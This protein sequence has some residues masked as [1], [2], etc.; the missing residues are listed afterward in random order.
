MVSVRVSTQLAAGYAAVIVAVAAV[1]VASHLYV[2]AV[3]GDA[4]EIAA[5]WDEADA[6]ASALATLREGCRTPEARRAIEEQARRI[7]SLVTGRP[8]DPLPVH[9][10]REAKIF[11]ATIAHCPAPMQRSS[12]T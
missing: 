8:G 3:E 4:G 5:E 1:A 11:G 10:E 2:R 7:E 12:S 9:E 6:L